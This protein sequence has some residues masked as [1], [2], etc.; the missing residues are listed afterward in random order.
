MD[1]EIRVLKRDEVKK[2]LDSGV[3]GWLK[4]R[5]KIIKKILLGLIGKQTTYII[6][7]L[8]IKIP[9]YPAQ[10]FYNDGRYYEIIIHKICIRGLRCNNLI[11]RVFRFNNIDKAAYTIAKCIFTYP[12]MI[13]PI[14]ELDECHL[15]ANKVTEKAFRLLGR[16]L[17]VKFRRLNN[18]KGTN[19]YLKEEIKEGDTE[20]ESDLYDLDNKLDKITIPL[21]KY[22]IKRSPKK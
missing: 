20:M 21:T 3:K 15:L 1:N 7:R 8:S 22:L 6:G 5:F 2:L 19:G 17:T 10:L 11:K 16:V 12:N 13:A 9:S 18:Q 14:K 4:A